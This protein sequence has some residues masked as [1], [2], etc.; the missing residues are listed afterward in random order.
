M[1]FPS[2]I[3]RVG[4]GPFLKDG[5][6]PGARHAVIRRMAQM[7]PREDVHQ[8]H[9]V[10]ADV[11]PTLIRS[12]MEDILLS[13]PFCTS[14][15]C[16]DMFRYVVERTLK[17]ERESL[18]ERVIG[19]E[20]FRKRNDYDTSEDPVV[21]VR[22]ADI[23]KRLAQYYLDAAHANIGVRIEI[24]SGSYVA[25]FEVF[26][27]EHI[28]PSVDAGTA[29]A[30]TEPLKPTHTVVSATE[31]ARNIL[32]PH[33]RYRAFWILASL[34]VVVLSAIVVPRV[35][36][37]QS[38]VLEQFW[39]PVLGSSKPVLIY[40]GANALYRLSTGFLD[41]YRKEHHIENQGP[42]FFAS[43]SSTE[44]ID[45]SDLV[46]VTNTT[47]D[48]K[49]CANVV[50]LLT[51]YQHPYEIRYGSD[52]AKGDLINS[53]AIL[54]GAFNNSWTLNITHQLRF[55]FKE[56]DHIEDTRGKTRDWPIVKGPNGDIQDDYAVITRLLDAKTGQV[57]I[58][59]AGIG[60]LGTEAA[61]DFLTSPRE[62]EELGQSAPTG[63]QKMNMQVVLHVKVL[64]QAFDKEN[65]LATEF[66]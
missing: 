13:T 54:I 65:I 17:H 26:P 34:I 33:F 39:S 47:A 59:A 35:F 62:M 8:T 9:Q 4:C 7:A 43:F 12:A 20:V 32:V 45:A 23:R 42:E 14:K 50:S 24:P 22:A 11:E 5:P 49:A 53:P 41:R 10:T 61:V 56:G 15:Q 66:W 18:R 21:R 64:N 44:K 2:K 28:A 40:G 19:I 16:Q 6:S 51:R 31:Q 38:S 46:P 57:V 36:H 25:V 27:Q 58:S 55:V 30:P 37:H 52:I 48:P 1:A 3:D 63:W 29:L 60:D